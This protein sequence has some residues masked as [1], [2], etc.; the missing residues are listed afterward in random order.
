MVRI[1]SKTLSEFL[2]LVD[3]HGKDPNEVLEYMIK[4]YV[5]EYY[6]DTEDELTKEDKG[7]KEDD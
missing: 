2:Q 7:E 3:S 5:D 6:D 4:E 1:D